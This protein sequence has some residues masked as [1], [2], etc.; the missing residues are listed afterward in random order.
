MN[1]HKNVDK[2]M[3]HYIFE[4]KKTR[5]IKLL[6]LL[7]KWC[8]TQAQFFLCAIIVIE[9]EYLCLFLHFLK[10]F[11]YFFVALASP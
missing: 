11:F 10:I 3:C 1:K 8:Q 6:E 2:E 9:C 7:D 4:L 5:S